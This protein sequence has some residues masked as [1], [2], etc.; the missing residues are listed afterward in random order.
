MASCNGSR[1]VAITVIASYRLLGAHIAE[2]LRRALLDERTGQVRQA[3]RGV[4]RR[5]RDNGQDDDQDVIV[6]TA[7]SLCLVQTCL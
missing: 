4:L 3:A 1:S 5:R 7:P 6:L 2:Q